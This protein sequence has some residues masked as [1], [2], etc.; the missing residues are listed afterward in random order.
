MLL[1]SKSTEFGNDAGAEMVGV[2]SREVREPGIFCVAPDSFVGIQLG[3]I[4]RKFGSDDSTMPAQKLPNGLGS[5]VDV[6]PI[7]NERH[8]TAD[9]SKEKTQKFNDVLRTDVFVIRQELKVEPQSFLYGTQRNSADGGDSVSAIPA[10][11]DRRL[12]ARRK[13]AADHWSQHEP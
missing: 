2:N 13:R 4:W 8:R 12:P 5:V 9:L 1:F 6:A 11:M 10:M 7:P 3:G